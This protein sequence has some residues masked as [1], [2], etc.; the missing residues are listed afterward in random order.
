[1]NRLKTPVFIIAEAGVNHN[2]SLI[3]AK[4][5]VDVAAAAGADAVKFQTFDV[6]TLVTEAAPKAKYQQTSTKDTEPQAK[7]LSELALTHDQFKTLKCYCEDRDILFLSSPFEEASAD[8]LE[9]IGMPIFKIPSGEIT[10]L[11]FIQHVAAKGKPFIVS[12]GMSSINEIAA[13]IDKIQLAGNPP[14]TLLHCVSAYPTAPKDVNLRAMK[15]L[16]EQFDVPIGFSDHTLGCEIS[17]AATALGA[18]VI[19][20]HF[21]MAREQSGPDHKASLEPI[22]LSKLIRGIRNIEVALGNGVKEPVAAEIPTAAAARKSLVAARIIPV[23][24]IIK[25][26]MVVVRRP[27]SGLAPR[28]I[29]SIIGKRARYSIPCGTPLT[30]DMIR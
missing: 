17:F 19:E 1:M 27:G 20:K 29:D 23:N 2:G 30:A 25:R 14:V 5:L 9:E 4:K 22:E 26:D 16:A 28:E 18:T 11:S 12:T 7:M 8:F 15:T 21:T 24:T 3:N 6:N 10:N 13:A